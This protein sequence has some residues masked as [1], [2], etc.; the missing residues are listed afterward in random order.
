MRGGSWGTEEKIPNWEP[1]EDQEFESYHVILRWF[2]REIV[3]VR[4]A[5][6]KEAKIALAGV[7]AFINNLQPY[8][9][10]FTNP[11]VAKCY[12]ANKFW[13]KPGRY[14]KSKPDLLPFE[15]GGSSYWSSKLH[16][17]IT[18]S[19]GKDNNFIP[20]IGQNSQCLMNSEI[21]LGLHPQL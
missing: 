5:S 11:L 17:W 7:K 13:T 21:S 3:K 1:A 16:C 10:D 2:R 4:N 6:K 20:P 14:S 18:G 9:P 19:Y 15:F 8:N 12:E